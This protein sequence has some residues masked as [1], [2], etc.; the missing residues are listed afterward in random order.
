MSQVVISGIQQI[1]IGVNDVKK[2]WQWYRKYFGMDIRAFEDAAIANYM[3]PYT[4]GQ[5]RE[6][7]VAF[8]TQFAR[9]WWL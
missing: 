6:R 7:F 1:G 4:G 5:P 9:R 2:S 8:N 3:L